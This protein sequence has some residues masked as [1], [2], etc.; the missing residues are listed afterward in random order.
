MRKGAVE[1]REK[2]KFEKGRKKTRKITEEGE[3]KKRDEKRR[4]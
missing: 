1:E 2:E 4:Q 3:R